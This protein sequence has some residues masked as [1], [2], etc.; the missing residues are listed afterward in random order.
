MVQLLHR[1]HQDGQGF[2]KTPGRP[3]RVTAV[4]PRQAPQTKGIA[5]EQQAG[6]VGGLHLLGLLSHI[7]H[8]QPCQ[9]LQ[10][11]VGF[12]GATQGRQG[13]VAMGH[14]LLGQHQ[15]V[16][17]AGCVVGPEVAVEQG[18]HS[19]LPHSRRPWIGSWAAA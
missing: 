9:L 8:F 7:H 12:G 11:L 16:A 10:N 13:A 2:G 17:Q 14:K 15:P 19:R 4:W 3:A 18:R 1:F 5:L 6:A